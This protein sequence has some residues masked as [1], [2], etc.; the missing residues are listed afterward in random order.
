[1][2][3]H[4]MPIIFPLFNKFKIKGIKGKRKVRRVG[5]SINDVPTCNLSESKKKKEKKS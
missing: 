4:S 3:S 2:Q 5:I 1:M